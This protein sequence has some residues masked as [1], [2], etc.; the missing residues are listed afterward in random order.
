MKIWNKQKTNTLDAARLFL[1][2]DFKKTLS[3]LNKKTNNFT[4]IPAQT[5]APIKILIELARY[6]QR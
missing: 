2:H 4:P 1:K 5:R 3:T 6:V